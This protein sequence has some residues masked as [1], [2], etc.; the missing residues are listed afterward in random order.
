MKD[1][2]TFSKRV[3][4]LSFLNLVYGRADVFLLG[5]LLSRRRPRDLYNGGLPG[6]G[7]DGFAHEYAGPSADAHLFPNSE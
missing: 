4:G 3:F 6:P 1:L 2:L 7:S 5:R